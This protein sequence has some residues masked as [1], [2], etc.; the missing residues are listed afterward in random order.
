VT[1]SAVSGFELANVSL[2]FVETSINW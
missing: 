2:Y 1:T